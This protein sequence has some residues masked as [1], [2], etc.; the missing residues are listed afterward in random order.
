MIPEG[1]HLECRKVSLDPGSKSARNG[2]LNFEPCIFFT[3]KI[4][5]GSASCSCSSLFGD[6]NSFLISI[7][8]SQLSSYGLKNDS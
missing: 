8:H 2:F 7:G 4:K 5:Q 1:K 6:A 3:I